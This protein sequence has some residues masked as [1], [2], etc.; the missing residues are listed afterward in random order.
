M[1]YGT[2]LTVKAYWP[3]VN[4]FNYYSN[5]FLFYHVNCF[6]IYQRFSVVFVVVMEVMFFFIYLTL[7]VVSIFDI[8]NTQLKR[9]LPSQ[10]VVIALGKKKLQRD[11]SDILSDHYFQR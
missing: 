5:S 9:Y 6:P 7:Y 11:V 10:K 4:H 2:Q 1:G 3:F 8:L